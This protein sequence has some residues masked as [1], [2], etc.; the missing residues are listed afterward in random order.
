MDHYVTL[1]ERPLASSGSE[2]RTK[3]LQ[4]GKQEDDAPVKCKLEWRWGL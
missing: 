4:T 2:L 3:T 1:S